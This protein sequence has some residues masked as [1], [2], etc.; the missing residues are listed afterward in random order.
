[1]S[2]GTPAYMAPEKHAMQRWW[3][4]ADLFGCLLYRALAG[5]HPFEARDGF[6]MVA[7]LTCRLPSSAIAGRAPLLRSLLGQLLR[8]MRAPGRAM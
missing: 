1:M 5:A 3:M 6:G 2:L 7:R 8:K 4:R